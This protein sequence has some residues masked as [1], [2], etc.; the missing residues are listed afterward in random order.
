VYFDTS[1]D[2]VELAVSIFNVDRYSYR[3]QLRRSMR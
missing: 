1:G 2:L 3:L